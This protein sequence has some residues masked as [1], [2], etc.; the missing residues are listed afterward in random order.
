[1]YGRMLMDY[2]VKVIVRYIPMYTGSCFHWSTKFVMPLRAMLFMPVWMKCF[3]WEMINVRAVRTIRDH[4]RQKN[5]ELWIWGDRLLDG[6]TTGMGMW[7]A[8]FNNTH[9]A[10]DMVPKD[11]VICDWHYERADKTAVYF[12]MKG[13]RVITCPWRNPQVGAIQV[14]D[15]AT[16]RK[17]A[18]PELKENYQGIM[19]TVW[20]D[21]ES[22]LTGFY[23]KKKDAKSNEENTPWNCFRVIYSK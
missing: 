16:F 19:Q 17:D 3:T 1:M 23:G 15:M 2:I 12:A 9:R 7:E 11:I 18:T 13:L 20:S 14:A 6:K 22:F 5:R 10:I 21:A 4:L 8:S